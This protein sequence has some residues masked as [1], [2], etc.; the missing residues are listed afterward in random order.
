MERGKT[1]IKN[2]GHIVAGLIITGVM[3]VASFA[4]MI[5]DP[6]RAPLGK[7][8]VAASASKL[9]WLDAPK[10]AAATPFE[11]AAGVTHAFADFHGRVLV[12]NFWATWCAPC[13]R[14]MPTLDALQSRLGGARFQVV[15]IN[16]DREGA[17]VAGPFLESKGLRH[18]TTYAEPALHFVRD[19]GL[20]GLPT[21]LVIDR[22][23]RE[24]A[25]LEGTA[26]WDSPEM[27]ATLQ[28]I[29]DQP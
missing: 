13:V 15:A 1:T 16:Q 22:D 28:R 26:D 23:G 8:A 9:E 25:R 2:H 29:I 6:W 7:P 11:D 14:E 3:A 19:A 18:L 12:V 10:P 24:I 21:S 20:R 4:L 27:V 17:K 5:W